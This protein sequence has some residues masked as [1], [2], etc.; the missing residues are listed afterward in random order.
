MKKAKTIIV[1]DESKDLYR[2]HFYDDCI[3]FDFKFAEVINDDEEI[4]SETIRINLDFYQDKIDFTEALQQIAIM[5]EKNQDKFS[6]F[7]FKDYELNPQGRYIDLVPIDSA[8]INMNEKANEFYK[9]LLEEG[10]L[11]KIDKQDFELNIKD[12]VYKDLYVENYSKIYKN[13][14]LIFYQYKLSDNFGGKNCNII[15]TEEEVFFGYTF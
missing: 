3:K 7:Y 12:E 2:I 1:A 4:K 9:Y 14:D 11:K 13:K 6:P 5:I 10:A 15:A 8:V